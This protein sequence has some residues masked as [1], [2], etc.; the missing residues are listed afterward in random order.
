MCKISW[1]KIFSNKSTRMFF[2]AV[3]LADKKEINIYLKLSKKGLKIRD[4]H[5]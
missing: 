3:V 5:I 1:G 4:N 2:V